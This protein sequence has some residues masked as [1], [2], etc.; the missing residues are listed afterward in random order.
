MGRK[1]IRIRIPKPVKEVIESSEAAYAA[2]ADRI[3][4][5]YPTMDRKKTIEEMKHKLRVVQI[6]R[7]GNLRAVTEVR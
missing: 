3:L 4:H 2:F 6:N 7:D 1:I 5:S